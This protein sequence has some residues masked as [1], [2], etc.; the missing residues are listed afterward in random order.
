MSNERAILCGSVGDGS[1]PF[2]DLGPLRLRMWGSTGTS[3]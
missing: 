2:K 3:T 1:L